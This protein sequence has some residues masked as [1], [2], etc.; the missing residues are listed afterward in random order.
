M[1]EGGV[2]CDAVQSVHGS[3]IQSSLM[4]G[5]SNWHNESMSK[6]FTLIQLRYFAAVA[7]SENMSAAA[8][9]LRISQSALSASIAALER[10]VGVQ[11][12]IRRPQRGLTLSPAGRQFAQEL[13]A[14]LEHADILYD[15]ARGLAANLGG[16]LTVGV[17]A[18]LAP[19]RAPIIL[20]AF[21]TEHPSVR[22][23]FLEGD[24]EYVRA[25]LLDG[26]CELALMYDIGLGGGFATR[27]LEHIAAHVLVH[28]GHRLARNPSRAVPL[29]DLEDEPMI[30]LDLPH[31]REYYMRVFD[32]A[33]VH[34]NIRHRA[35]GYETVRA[36]VAGGHGY[37][38]LNQRLSHDLTYVGR[39]VVPV[40]IADDV[41]GIDVMLVRPDGVVPTRRA[42]A[43]EDVCRRIYAAEPPAGSIGSK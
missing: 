23:S 31:T 35:S 41:P 34:P 27:T 43:F 19:F 33:G 2:R 1:A 16:E 8:G 7:R 25:A 30:L 4:L 24:Q 13:N 39:P 21:E 38:V 28:D 17:F 32:Q 10:E 11:L 42:L 14:F 36:F 20:R 9:E 29:A 40:S 26:R 15:S 6:D 12:F 5:E 22:V 18:P 37:S 3:N